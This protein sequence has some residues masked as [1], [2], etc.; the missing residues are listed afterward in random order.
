MIKINESFMMLDMKL[1]YCLK[2]IPSVPLFAVS[3]K[4]ILLY[5]FINCIL[6][7]VNYAVSEKKDKSLPC[8]KKINDNNKIIQL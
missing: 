7:I 6:A 2:Y 1:G 4:G 8:L 3:C 5:F